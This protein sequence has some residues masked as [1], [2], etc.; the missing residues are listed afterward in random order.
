MKQVQRKEGVTEMSTTVASAMLHFWFCT[1][2]KKT[3]RNQWRYRN[4]CYV[5]HPLYTQCIR[6]HHTRKQIGHL[7]CGRRFEDTIHR[8]LN[9]FHPTNVLIHHPSQSIIIKK[10]NKGGNWKLV[11]VFFSYKKS[12]KQTKKHISLN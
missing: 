7:N 3:I 1:Y 9:L 10:N 12:K 6:H 2:P 5:R 8:Y 11:I 4:I